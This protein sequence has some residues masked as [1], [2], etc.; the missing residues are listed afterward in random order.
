MTLNLEF[1]DQGRLVAIK[2]KCN[3]KDLREKGLIKASM[4]ARL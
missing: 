1:D 3:V 4:E 2:G